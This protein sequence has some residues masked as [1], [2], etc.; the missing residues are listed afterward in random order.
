MLFIHVLPR[1]H[2]IRWDLTY[3]GFEP[4]LSKPKDFSR[5]QLVQI[6]SGITSPLNLI[7]YESMGK[8]LPYSVHG[9][10]SNLIRSLNEH[11]WT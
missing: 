1:V 11:K 7:H 9:V 6:T 3:K 2:P 4:S 5:S 10:S 8:I